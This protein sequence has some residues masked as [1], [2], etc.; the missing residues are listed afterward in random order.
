MRNKQFSFWRERLQGVGAESEDALT[1]MINT[2]NTELISLFSFSWGGSTLETTPRRLRPPLFWLERSF[3]THQRRE[4]FIVHASEV[5]AALWPPELFSITII[6]CLI[7]IPVLWSDLIM[8][9]KPARLDSLCPT[10]QSPHLPRQTSNSHSGKKLLHN[11]N[12]YGNQLVSIFI[13]TEEYLI[14]L[15]GLTHGWTKQ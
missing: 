3:L 8:I 12:L 15:I 10:P 5:C 7:L 1:R 2:E 14:L 13:Q 11:L 6:S 4:M 9:I